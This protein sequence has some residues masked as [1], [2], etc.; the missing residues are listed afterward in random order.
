M[1][2][3]GGPNEGVYKKIQNYVFRFSDLLGQGN[4]S[5]VYAGQHEISRRCKKSIRL[6]GRHQDRGAGEPQEP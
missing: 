5:K 6:G 1:K 4:F 3:N 2:A